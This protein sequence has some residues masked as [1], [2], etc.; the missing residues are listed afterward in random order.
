[1]NLPDRKTIEEWMKDAS[2][3]TLAY[4]GTDGWIPHSYHAAEAARSIA[5]AAGMDETLAWT[6]AVLHDIGRQHPNG[7]DFPLCHGYYGYKILTERGY[8]E[9]ARYCLTHCKSIKEEFNE[10]KWGLPPAE[11][12]FVR[13]FLEAA[14]Y[15]DYDLLI[16]LAD[17]L[18]DKNGYMFLE[19]RVIDGAFRYKDTSFIK[20]VFAGSYKIKRYFDMKCGR[21]IYE[22]IPGFIEQALKFRYEYLEDPLK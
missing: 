8:P 1:M 22:I 19:S 20:P 2:R 12:K 15:D 14:R 13:D 4:G 9:L 21:S 5:L 18:A 10:A 17:T 16:L 3:A 6:A 11:L 7:M